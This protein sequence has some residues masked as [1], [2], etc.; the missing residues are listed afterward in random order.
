[1]PATRGRRGSQCRSTS[2]KPGSPPSAVARLSTLASRRIGSVYALPVAPRSVAVGPRW[3]SVPRHPIHEH[4]PFCKVDGHPTYAPVWQDEP[5]S[6]SQDK[7]Y[8]PFSY[9]I[10]KGTSTSN[11]CPGPG[12]SHKSAGASHIDTWCH[13]AINDEDFYDWTLANNTVSRLQYAAVS[14]HSRATPLARHL[15]W[16]ST[17]PTHMFASA[18]TVPG[19]GE[20]VFHHVGFCAVGCSGPLQQLR[21]CKLGCFLTPCSLTR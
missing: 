12:E 2:R 14:T 18:E 9:F 11:P 16:K 19:G 13:L 5:T 4:L 15:L 17:M 7:N 1:M 6:W 10:S 21:V 20:K 8:F 3:R